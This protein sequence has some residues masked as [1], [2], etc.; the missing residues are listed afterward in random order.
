MNEVVTTVASWLI[1]C[2]GIWIVSALVR[3][4]VEE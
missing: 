2:A 1:G 3:R 4:L